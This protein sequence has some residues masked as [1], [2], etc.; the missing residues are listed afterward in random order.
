MYADLTV[1]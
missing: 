1:R